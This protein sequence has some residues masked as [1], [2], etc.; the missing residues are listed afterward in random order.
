MKSSG[1][2]ST[3]TGVSAPHRYTTPYPPRMAD[4]L[5]FE[6]GSVAGPVV[7]AILL[8][9]P[10]HHICPATLTEFAEHYRHMCRATSNI[11]LLVSG[12][13]GFGNAFNV[14]RTVEG[15]GERWSGRADDR[16]PD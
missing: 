10:N 16:R 13:Q 7:Q 1:Q 3:V 4:A 8:A 14:M 2:S 15:I 11:G 9:A 5:G 12:M 6:V